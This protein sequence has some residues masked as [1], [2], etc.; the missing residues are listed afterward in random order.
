MH[1]HH[2]DA[3]QMYKYENMNCWLNAS[4]A[5]LQ[6]E[7]CVVKVLPVFIKKYDAYDAYIH[8]GVGVYMQHTYMT[9]MTRHTP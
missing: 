5:S 2:G 8:H 4:Y 7:I 6:L 3:G 1:I 9:H